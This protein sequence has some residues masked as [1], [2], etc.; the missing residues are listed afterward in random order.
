MLIL[1]PMQ[2]TLLAVC[3]YEVSPNAG[4][5][6]VAQNSWT[7]LKS[8]LN[9]CEGFRKCRTNSWSHN[10]IKCRLLR[11]V[12]FSQRIALLAFRRECCAASF[13]C[14]EHWRA[15]NKSLST[16]IRQSCAFSD[17]SQNSAR[18]QSFSLAFRTEIAS[19]STFSHN[20][21]DFTSDSSFQHGFLKHNGNKNHAILPAQLNWAIRLH[22]RLTERSTSTNSYRQV[23]NNGYLR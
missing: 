22:C 14:C 11:S 10:N 8:G 12:M 21:A 7:L 1:N 20:Q 2:T 15:R 9:S 3:L 23:H 5:K 6:S 4:K 17:T 18:P 19:I 13:C 16:Y